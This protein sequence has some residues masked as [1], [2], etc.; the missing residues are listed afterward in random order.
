MEGSNFSLLIKKFSRYKVGVIFFWVLVLM[1]FIVV[2]GGFISPYTPG[3]P[4]QGEAAQ[5]GEER[6]LYDYYKSKIMHPPT[7]IHSDGSIFEGNFRLYTKEHKRLEKPGYNVFIELGVE[8]SLS[9]LMRFIKSQAAESIVMNFPESRGNEPTQL[10]ELANKLNNDNKPI[11]I[12]LVNNSSTQKNNVA[13]LIKGAVSEDLRRRAVMKIISENFTFDEFTSIITN[14]SE[15]YSEEQLRQIYSGNFSIDGSQNIVDEVIE[16]KRGMAL[17]F[18]L[19]EMGAGGVNTKIENSQLIR[20]FDDML[21]KI[22]DDIAE[23]I[24]VQTQTYKMTDI[25]GFEG[26]LSKVK[27]LVREYQ[28]LSQEQQTGNIE[29]N[30]SEYPA[31]IQEAIVNYL[32]LQ[33][34]DL[35]V[36]NYYSEIRRSEYYDTISEETQDA[37]EDYY[38]ENI[39]RDRELRDRLYKEVIDNDP[40][41]LG[42]IF[43]E[44]VENSPQYQA[45]TVRG[46]IKD[47]PSYTAEEILDNIKEDIGEELLSN[48]Y[49]SVKGQLPQYVVSLIDEYQDTDFTVRQLIREV[50]PKRELDNLPDNE[51]TSV[52]SRDD[53]QNR[54]FN[55]QIYSEMS[56]SPNVID[57]FQKYT[58]IKGKNVKEALEIIPLTS[59]NLGIPTLREIA[60][61]KYTTDNDLAPILNDTVIQ[62][63]ED[64]NETLMQYLGIFVQEERRQYEHELGWFV[65]GEEYT[66]FWIFNTNIHL[67]GTKDRGTFYLL[68]ADEQGRCILSR[69]IYGGRISLTVGFLGMFMSVVIAVAIGGVAG[70]FG[71]MIDWIV[72]RI[73]E[74]MLLF[75]SFYLLLTL[76]GVLPTDLSPEQR[77][78]LIVIILSLIHWAG[79]ARVIRGFI[80]A[81]KNQD[82]VIAAQ[83][84]GV[85]TPLVILKHLLPQISSYLIVRISIGIPGY[86]MMETSLSW[87]GFGI[88][89]PSVSWGLMLSVLRELSI[90]SVA[91]DYPWLLWPA[92]IVSVTIMAFQLIGDAVR[93]TLDPMVKR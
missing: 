80:L 36:E 90:I 7:P 67:F 58:T 16:Q 38:N 13:G 30:L 71:G 48:N 83:V 92:V 74:I 68:G 47:T 32:E 76:R 41:L 40:E 25:I 20:L 81:G 14:I 49:V 51:F 62:A 33:S 11:F 1:Y 57:L 77:F 60:I 15:D 59:D 52:N 35:P 93:D 3:T 34:P 85:P 79:L 21:E 43:R 73:C 56:Q 65:E 61:K 66:L 22:P 63:V 75:P 64:G 37:F 54:V 50:V 12:K 44:V 78:I 42:D 87:L 10:I 72:M 69:I 26:K 45:T 18:I 29:N 23:N 89:E 88:S 28:E 86:I 9:D 70:Y 6:R 8:R 27:R 2:L 91:T 82:Y 31:I 84:Q 4:Y 19:K 24:M 39:R 17:D 53:L 55:E 5:G 46:L